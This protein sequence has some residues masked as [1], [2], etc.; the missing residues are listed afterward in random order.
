MEINAKKKGTDEQLLQMLTDPH[1]DF[2]TIAVVNGLTLLEFLTWANKPEITGALKGLRKLHR[3]R[4]DLLAQEA[5]SSAVKTLKGIVDHHDHELSNS[6]P[7]RDP[8]SV[9]AAA[10]Q[11]ETARKACGQLMRAAG[12]DRP[13]QHTRRTRTRCHQS[14]RPKA[15]AHWCSPFNLGSATHLS[16]VDST[17]QP[18]GDITAALGTPGILQTDHAVA[19][20]GATP[21][22]GEPPHA[23]SPPSIG[24]PAQRQHEPDERDERRSIVR[25]PG[26]TVPGALRVA[27]GQPLGLVGGDVPAVGKPLGEDPPSL[28]NLLGR[29]LVPVGSLDDVRL[30]APGDGPH[31]VLGLPEEQLEPQRPPGLLREERREIAVGR[32]VERCGSPTGTDVVEHRVPGKLVGEV[33]PD[34]G[35]EVGE[36]GRGVR[37]LDAVIQLAAGG[38][39]VPDEERGAQEVECARNAPRPHAC[40]VGRPGVQG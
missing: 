35:A 37:V 40:L 24:D 22:L 16:R 31:A 2:Q 15:E 20:A 6:L 9:A 27:A 8:K 38:R 5:A 23:A 11:S 4:T 7:S 10:R 34:V 29:E 36:G 39:D 18:L 33:V 19:A 1:S 26:E 12:T 17:L 28:G 13:H 30:A 21:P 32:G 25:I 3:T 14:R